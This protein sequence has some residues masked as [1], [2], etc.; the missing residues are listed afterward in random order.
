METTLEFRLAAGDTGALG[1]CYREHSSA[2]RSYLR[3][4]VPPQDVEDVL[5][6]VFTEVWRFRH[7]FD[8]GRS[9]PAWLF[10]IAHNRAVDHLRARTPTTVPLEAVP[11]PAGHD[12]RRDGDELADRDRVL[13]ALA[14]LP[15]VQRQAIELAYYGDLTQREI[16]EH[17]R[18]PLGTVKARTARGL[19]RLSA[20]LEAA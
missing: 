16:A 4:L 11:D 8:P 12:G 18:V 7:R 14:A 3:K 2:V 5:Q 9:L 19:H 13:R 20:L 1:E 6:V 10:G 17:L 15:Q